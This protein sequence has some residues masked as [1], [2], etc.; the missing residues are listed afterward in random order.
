M[1]HDNTSQKKAA[2]AILILD[3]V[4]FKAKIP[5]IKKVIL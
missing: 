3:K 1:Y 5:G 4:S 2:G